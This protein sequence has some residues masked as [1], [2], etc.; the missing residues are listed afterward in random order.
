MPVEAASA[1]AVGL[2]KEYQAAVA[3]LEAIRKAGGNKDAIQG[4]IKKVAAAKKA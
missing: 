2:Q 4:A 3:E 1:E